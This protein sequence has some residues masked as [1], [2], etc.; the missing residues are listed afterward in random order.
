ATASLTNKSRYL[1]VRALASFPIFTV[2]S[3]KDSW[4]RRVRRG[5]GRR[6]MLSF[7]VAIV[8]AWWV[9]A[10]GRSAGAG[11]GCIAEDNGDKEGNR[12]GIA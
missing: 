7:V 8:A 2:L 11:S 1:A 10:W 3:S 4:R 12:G 9:G 6:G 5:I